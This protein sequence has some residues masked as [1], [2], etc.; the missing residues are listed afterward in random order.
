M[1]IILTLNSLMASSPLLIKI[2]PILADIFVFS[3]PLY[4]IYLY[5]F[6]HDSISRWQR[7]RHT[8]TDRQ[9]KYI[10]LSTLFSFIGSIIVNYIIKA[11]IEQPRPYQ[12]LDLAIDPKESLILSSIPT[13]SFPSDHAAVG[14]SIAIAILIRGYR[15][16]NKKIIIA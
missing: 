5:F 3:Y 9:H 15:T 10:A 2:V 13:D 14:A 12:V 6:T 1:E 11:F 16:D 8:A 7:L 4:L